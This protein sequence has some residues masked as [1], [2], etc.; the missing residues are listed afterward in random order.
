MPILAVALASWWFNEP[1]EP[2]PGPSPKPSGPTPAVAAV[3]PPAPVALRWPEE[4]VEGREAK[5]IALEVTRAAVAKLE[6]VKSYTATLKKRERLGGKLTPEMTLAMKVMHKPFSIYFRYIQPEAGKEIVYATGRHDGKLIAHA[7]GLARLV[8][9]RIA[10]KPDS[11][12]ALAEARHPVTE[13]GLKALARNL[14]KYREMDLDDPDD[15]AALDHA[16][17]PDGRLWPRSVHT[18]FRRYT[19]RPFIRSEVL[20][21]PDLLIPESVVN[22]DWPD[23]ST[24]GEPRLAES[25]EY[26]DVK[27]DVPL[28]PIDFDPANPKYAFHRF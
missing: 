22:H 17:G 24:G 6:G 11:P 10:V 19:D 20:Y 12:I 28:D 3:A 9:P 25:Y 7:T 1:F 14:L 4:R 2:A 8:A 23:P 18:H 13:A 5:V 27:F 15:E 26:R 21:H 16:P